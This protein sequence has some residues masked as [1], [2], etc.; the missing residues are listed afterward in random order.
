M[1]AATAT[2]INVHAQLVRQV[3]DSHLDPTDA[4]DDLLSSYPGA[5]PFRIQGMLEEVSYLRYKASVLR[6]DPR[7][8]LW[9]FTDTPN[10]S[11][12]HAEYLADRAN[13]EEDALIADWVREAL[14]HEPVTSGRDVL[15]GTVMLV[16]ACGMVAVMLMVAS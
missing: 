9:K 15:W 3:L 7:Y 6:G 8:G 1:A 13:A 11:N 4:F 10:A 16:L 2:Q 12:A 14:D 5:T